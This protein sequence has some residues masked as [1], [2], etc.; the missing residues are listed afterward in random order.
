MI[1][2]SAKLRGVSGLREAVRLWSEDCEH[3][4]YGC[5]HDRISEWFHDDHAVTLARLVLELSEALEDDP[6]D[7]DCDKCE[8]CIPHYDGAVEHLKR[9]TAALAHAEEVEL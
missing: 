1:A 7:N 5:E 2:P 9:R 3:E 4:S 6:C 8:F